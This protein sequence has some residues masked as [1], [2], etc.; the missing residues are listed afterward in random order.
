MAS[1]LL[2][3]FSFGKFLNFPQRLSRFVEMTWRKKKGKIKNGKSQT[4]GLYLKR[5]GK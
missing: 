5:P 1:L 3:D 4:L 2:R